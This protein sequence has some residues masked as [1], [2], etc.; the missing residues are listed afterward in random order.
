[1]TKVET[2]KLLGIIGAMYQSYQVTDEKIN[3]WHLLIKDISFPH[4]QQALVECLKTSKFPPVAAEIIERAGVIRLIESRME[5][6]LL[7][8][9]G[10]NIAIKEDERSIYKD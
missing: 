6:S 2:T 5:G 4:A 7:D 9:T 8:C 10:N 1:M 3:I